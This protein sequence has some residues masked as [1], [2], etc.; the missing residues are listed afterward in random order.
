M[1][2][3]MQE[4]DGN[5]HRKWVCARDFNSH[6]SLWDGDGRELGGSLHKV[7]DLTESGR[8]MIEPGTPM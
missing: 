4:S 5:R 7:K 6:Y 2:N 3:I 8:L 1:M